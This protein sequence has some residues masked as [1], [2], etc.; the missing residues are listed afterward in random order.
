ML[1]AICAKHN[2]ATIAKF[3]DLTTTWVWKVRNQL[4]KS[5]GDYEAVAK[6]SDHQRSLR[7]AKFINHVK[8]AIDKDP[9]KSMHAIAKDMKTS[10]A[11]YEM[12]VR[13]LEVQVQQNEKRPITDSQGQEAIEVLSKT[14][15]Q[16]QT[17]SA[18]QHHLVLL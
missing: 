16:T 8:N 17:S 1:F 7:T 10:E 2:N 18:A 15:Q 13:G 4:E 11:L 14:S 6:R 12:C 9:G 5:G 3:F